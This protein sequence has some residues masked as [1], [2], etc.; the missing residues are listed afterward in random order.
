VR[1]LHRL[2]ALLLCLGLIAGNA[3][4]CA[5]WAAAPEARMACCTDDG[6]CSMHTRESGDSGSGRALT[7]AQVD[8][9]C[10]SSERKNSSPS[11]PTFVAT[12]SFAALGPGVVLPTT[13][14]ALVLSDEWRTVSPVPATLVP[15]HIL[16]TV[17]LV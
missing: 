9:C 16:L 5:G 12:I 11:T 10:A 17:F 7:Q 2:S 15:K 8:A 1:L 3:A 13:V 4:I 14:P 6:N